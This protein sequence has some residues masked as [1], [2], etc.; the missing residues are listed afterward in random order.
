MDQLVN[1]GKAPGSFGI[2][3]D[4]TVVELQAVGLLIFGFAHPFALFVFKV[5]Q[6][7][8]LFIH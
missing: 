1:A 4:L 6:L 7:N 3:L 8:D 5:K 2:R